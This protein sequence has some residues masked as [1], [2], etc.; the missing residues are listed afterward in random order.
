MVET[1]YVLNAY[2][3]V[4]YGHES[5]R[6]EPHQSQHVDQTTQNVYFSTRNDSSQSLT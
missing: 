1:M 6:Y 4:F 2:R 3:L 5:S